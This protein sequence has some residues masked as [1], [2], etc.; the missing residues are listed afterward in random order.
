MIGPRNKMSLRP[1]VAMIN[2]WDIDHA[3]MRR[4]STSS[5]LIASV[6]DP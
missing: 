2:L 6:G 5:G 3:G 1:P 4:T